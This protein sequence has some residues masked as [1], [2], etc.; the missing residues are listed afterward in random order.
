MKTSSLLQEYMA[1]IFQMKVWTSLSV[2]S[3]KTTQD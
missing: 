3:L 2:S 1:E